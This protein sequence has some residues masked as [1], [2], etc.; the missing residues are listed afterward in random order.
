MLHTFVPLRCERQACPIRIARVPGQPF[1][2]RIRTALLVTAGLLLAQGLLG[3][4]T[5]R[6]AGQPKEFHETAVALLPLSSTGPGMIV[7]SCDDCG[8]ACTGFAFL[9]Q[10]GTLYYFDRGRNTLS[11][12]RAAPT[13]TGAWETVPGPTIAALNDLPH[14]GCVSPDGTIW[15]L[16][17][18]ITLTNRYFVSR[19]SPG[20]AEWVRSEPL[21]DNTIG[22]TLLGGRPVQSAYS[23]RID[24]DLTGRLELYD[25]DRRSSEAIIL[26]DGG[27]ILGPIDRFRVPSGA[28]T[29]RGDVIG[30]RGTSTLV[31][32][33][34]PQEPEVEL[35]V[36]GIFLGTDLAGNFYLRVPV[37][38]TP[39]M[40]LQRYGP[41]GELLASTVVPNRPTVG[42][43]E[44]K[45]PFH[46]QPN[47]DV[48][49]FR[50]TPSGL[51]ITRWSTA[52]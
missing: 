7:A 42:L 24:D 51:E 44:G 50:V 41:D 43:L 1:T 31:R 22:W 34:G 52:E 37:R 2:L 46:L 32:R 9:D 12:L 39:A 38:G 23:A 25:L 10:Q 40:S 11:S 16:T 5:A 17:D 28:R 6:S 18:R 36:P 15:L 49:Q 20:D 29:R 30:T 4:G 14:D 45:G 47:G 26:A 19:R 13:G 35:K 3:F 33:T 8:D 21:D 48:M 27:D